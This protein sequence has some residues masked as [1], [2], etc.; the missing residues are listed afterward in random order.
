MVLWVII[1]QKGQG[2]WW[3]WN[4]EG[5][6][7]RKWQE[8]KTRRKQT[9]H[10]LHLFVHSSIKHMCTR[11]HTNA[12]LQTAPFNNCQLSD[13]LTVFCSLKAVSHCR[14]LV[15]LPIYPTFSVQLVKEQTRSP[16]FGPL[17]TEHIPNFGFVGFTVIKKNKIHIWTQ[18]VSLKLT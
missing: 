15:N 7:A 8:I 9:P 13:M 3:R 2:E 18:N 5:L 1:Q 17:R 10:R 4:E 14:R 6:L 16:T 12:R 11:T